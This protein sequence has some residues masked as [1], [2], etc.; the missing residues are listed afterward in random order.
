MNKDKTAVG[1]SN[2]GE[3]ICE[4]GYNLSSVKASKPTCIP[5]I[6]TESILDIKLTDVYYTNNPDSS[7]VYTE[8]EKMANIS[9]IAKYVP[10][11]FSPE[12]ETRVIGVLRATHEVILSQIDYILLPINLSNIKLHFGRKVK[13]EEKE[14]YTEMLSQRRTK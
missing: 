14:F 12:L 9:N 3:K 6:N 11:W 10:T 8:N 5:N 13:T 4:F 1:Y 7:S 2:A